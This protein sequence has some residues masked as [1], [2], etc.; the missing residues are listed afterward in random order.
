MPGAGKSTVG[1]LLAKRMGCAFVD[2]DLLIQSDAGR[3][4][5]DLIDNDGLEAFRVREERIVCDL[6]C[7]RTV[8][9]TGGSVVYSEASMRHL[10]ALGVVVFLRL[11]LAELERRIGDPGSR[12]LMRRPGQSI[13]DLYTERQPR[14]R[15]HAD[16]TIDCE[17]LVPSAVVEAVVRALEARL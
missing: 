14:Y 2:T 1:V 7:R 3:T 4:L 16:V 5:Q 10:H 9:A 13:S 11:D 6:A 17:G 15:R 8:I 12:G